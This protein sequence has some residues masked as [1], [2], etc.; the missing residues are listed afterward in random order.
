MA[1]GHRGDLLG[2]RLRLFCLF[3]AAAQMNEERCPRL[4][5]HAVQRMGRE[6]EFAR[7][8]SRVAAAGQQQIDA[9][10]RQRCHHAVQ[11]RRIALRLVAQRSPLLVPRGVQRGRPCRGTLSLGLGQ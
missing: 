9:A 5:A 10:L 8:P 2:Q 3:G 6:E 1:L 4:H 11:P 7:Q